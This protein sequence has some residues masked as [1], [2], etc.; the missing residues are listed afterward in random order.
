MQYKIIREMATEVY[1][2]DIFGFTD[3]VNK[4]ISEG[5]T[6]IGGVC[7]FGTNGDF[8]TDTAYIMQAVIKE[9]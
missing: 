6:P 3:K 2:L 7:V 5:W 9:D 1:K 8:R 4:A